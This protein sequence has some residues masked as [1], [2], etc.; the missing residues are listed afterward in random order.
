[1]VRYRKT[2]LAKSQTD[3]IVGELKCPVLEVCV[4]GWQSIRG[5]GGCGEHLEH[6]GGEWKYPV[7][8]VCV[9][10]WQPI[11]GGGGCGEH[12]E[13]DGGEWKYPVPEVCVEGWQPI[14]G[15]G[16]CGEHL[17]HDGGV[18]AR[19]VVLRLSH[20]GWHEAS[21][22][23]KPKNCIIYSDS[24]GFLD[25]DLNRKSGSG[26]KK[27]Y[28]RSG[29]GAGTLLK[30]PDPAPRTREQTWAGWRWARR[31]RPGSEEVPGVAPPAPAAAAAGSYAGSAS[32]PAGLIIENVYHHRLVFR[33]RWIRKWS[34]LLDPE[35][36]I[37]DSRIRI[38]N[39]ELSIYESGSVIP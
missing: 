35:Y 30:W 10:G 16:G 21:F 23:P 22:L 37:T 28:P 3:K 9:E 31:R 1:M 32:P 39:T 29:I 34:G 33:V 19:Q 15:G 2:F 5:G 24:M 11:R 4:E 26:H 27:N 36:L 8:E 14:R 25:P 17:E 18:L 13:H 7:P 38:H 20:I 6:D 12:L